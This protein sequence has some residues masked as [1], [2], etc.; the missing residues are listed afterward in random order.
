MRRHLLGLDLDGTALN[1]AG[2]LPADVKAAIINARAK[3]HIVCF[4]T[5]RTDVEM[6]PLGDEPG[7]VDYLIKNNG[8]KIVDVA[9]G[10]LFKNTTVSPEA[11]RQLAGFCLQ[12]DYLLYVLCGLHLAVNKI[13]PDA[14]NFFAGLQITPQVF[15]SAEELRLNEIDAFMST[16]HAEEVCAFIDEASLALTYKESEPFCV[17]IVPKGIGKWDALLQVCQREN[18]PAADVIAVGNYYNDIDM[19]VHAGLGIAVAGSPAEVLQAAH[20]TTRADNN[21]GAVAEVIHELLL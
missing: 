11:V 18:I 15:S 9:R 16:D 20:R 17:D 5:G 1:D 10:E 3:G 4:V 13:T 7:C 2:R 21:S 12:K 19:L 14:A 6:L 8:G